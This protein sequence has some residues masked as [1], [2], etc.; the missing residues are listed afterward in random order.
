MKIVSVQPAPSSRIPGIRRVETS[1]KWIRMVKFDSVVDDVEEDEAIA[2]AVE[3]A[4]C[5]G[6]LVGLSS[7]AVAAGLRRAVDELGL[8]EGDYL[9]AFPDYG[10][11][12]VEQFSRFL[13][14]DRNLF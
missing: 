9:L 14:Q 2:T 12:Y 13:E 10:F 3:I 4:K 5:E 7:G 6:I 8:G 1:M 11:K